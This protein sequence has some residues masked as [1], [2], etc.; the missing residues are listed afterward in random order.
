MEQRNKYST[1]LE[2][3]SLPSKDLLQF[4]EVTLGQSYVLKHLK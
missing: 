2:I 3:E 4:V 1:L